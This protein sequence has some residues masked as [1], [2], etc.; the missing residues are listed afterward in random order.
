M[1]WSSF[2]RFSG[3]SP[4]NLQ[5]LSVYGKL[6][7]RILSGMLVFYAVQ[8]AR[9]TDPGTYERPFLK[10]THTL[11]LAFYPSTLVYYRFSSKDSVSLEF[12]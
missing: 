2:C 10:I 4:E 3:D 11:N 1:N 9:G 5:K 12:A 8:L 7:P 6:I